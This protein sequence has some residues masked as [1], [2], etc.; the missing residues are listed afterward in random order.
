ML[1]PSS[2]S[3]EDV[4]IL[5]LEYE[6]ETDEETETIET[7]GYLIVEQPGDLRATH[8]IVTGLNYVGRE[9][10]VEV[11]LPSKEVSELHCCI[12]ARGGDG[13]EPIV[14]IEDMGSKN[15]TY[16]TFNKQGKW[17]KLV[18]W[19]KYGIMDGIN[20]KF[21]RVTGRYEMAIA[22]SRP[23]VAL[24]ESQYPL[25]LDLEFEEKAKRRRECSVSSTGPTQLIT[26]AGV[27]PA[28]DN[29]TQIIEST[30]PL[31]P[32]IMNKTGTAPQDKL[33]PT[34]MVSPIEATLVPA[35]IEPTLPQEEIAPTLVVN[36][37]LPDLKLVANNSNSNSHTTTTTTTSTFESTLQVSL[38]PTLRVNYSPIT[39][40]SPR[41]ARKPHLVHHGMAPNGAG[42]PDSKTEEE[43]PPRHSSLRISQKRRLPSSSSS[44]P[45]G[46]STSD[47]E[48]TPPVKR[49]KK[50]RPR[51]EKGT[52]PPPEPKPMRNIMATGILLSERHLEG[53][54]K[55]GG[56]VVTEPLRC[57][58]LVTNEVK[59][60]VKLL[61][62][63][64]VADDIVS[65]DWVDACV[66]AGRWV[67]TGPYAF[68]NTSVE[69]KFSFSLKEALQRKHKSKVFTGIDFVLSPNVHPQ[70][71]DSLGLRDIIICGGGTLHKSPNVP[72]GAIALTT[73]DDVGYCHEHF[74]NATQYVTTEWLFLASLR[75]RL[76]TPEENLVLTVEE[77]H[78]K[79]KH[80]S[81]AKHKA[82]PA[83]KKKRRTAA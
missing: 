16:I 57:T 75:Q 42:S 4:N 67:P 83:P 32:S 61:C 44:P 25:S 10:D 36:P 20:F 33:T 53:I 63:M 27:K 2:S 11:M 50:V 64:S 78:P 19:T 15:L 13:E 35:V 40:G 80:S 26:A 31:T 14:M 71:P 68:K 5:P 69:E 1:S 58:I 52:L 6:A 30:A 8:P 66:K 34:L 60:T 9:G 43:S 18:P 54:L 45:S 65:I 29:A 39:P 73:Q 51:V 17:I 72:R 70:K 74:A 37:P 28:D 62:A 23:K 3:T 77:A 82:K 79:P 47:S 12:E 49:K 76:P 56:T 24:L 41:S 48:S 7:V 22:H 21:G 46:I 81:K 59:R 55:M 38:D